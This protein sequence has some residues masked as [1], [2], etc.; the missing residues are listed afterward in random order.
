MKITASNPV[1]QILME[2]DGLS[3]DDAMER[4]QEVS[5]EMNQSLDI[6]ED[7]LREELGL[8]PDYLFDLVGL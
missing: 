6:A 2:R 5:D 4:V 8:E 3:E 1:V 7:T